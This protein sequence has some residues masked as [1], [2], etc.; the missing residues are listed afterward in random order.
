MLVVLLLLLQPHS[1][2]A[3][4]SPPPP[5]LPLQVLSRTRAFLHSPATDT[6]SLVRELQSIADVANRLDD[7]EL[8]DMSC[9][10]L[11]T[12][13]SP[14]DEPYALCDYEDD[15]DESSGRTL[16]QYDKAQGSWYTLA[17][18]NQVEFPPAR[19][20]Q[21]I[22]VVSSDSPG[23]AVDILFPSACNTREFYTSTSP[24]TAWKKHKFNTVG[25]YGPVEC[26]AAAVAEGMFIAIETND[27]SLIRVGGVTSSSGVQLTSVNTFNNGTIGRIA[28]GYGCAAT[29]APDG[30][31]YVSGG[32]WPNDG[33]RAVGKG[34][35]EN[36]LSSRVTR[37]VIASDMETTTFDEL[38]G[39]PEG[40]CDH[41]MLLQ[42]G[43]L[44]AYG[45]M[46]RWLF[47]GLCII[48]A[49]GTSTS[50][51]VARRSETHLVLLLVGPHRRL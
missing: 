17:A 5:P 7:D 38:V 29:T 31:I 47:E 21:L 20:A 19:G 10:I 48:V 46:V 13:F 45:G 42:D 6:W 14:N 3:Q 35:D 24:S 41:A 1:A 16:I 30:T 50:C 26:I 36:A 15:C 25:V 51:G 49:R 43:H 8:D 34:V 28:R 4:A 32:L 11:Q 9:T 39:L 40:R 18:S 33:E 44:C 12:P 27:V 23:G 22:R 37:T 2:A